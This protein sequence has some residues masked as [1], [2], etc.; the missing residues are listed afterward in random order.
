M[1]DIARKRAE[2]EAAKETKAVAD[3]ASIGATLIRALP[4]DANGAARAD[5]L[6]TFTALANSPIKI[7]L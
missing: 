4:D 3:V 1:N 7:E 6:R 2:L 5:T